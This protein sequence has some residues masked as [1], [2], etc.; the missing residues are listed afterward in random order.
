[1]LR[2]AAL[3][4]RLLLS[5]ARTDK[6]AALE[7][8]FRA[9]PDPD[10]GWA[11]AA[12][13]G[14]LDLPR[15]SA[16]TIRRLCHA[17]VDATLFALSYDF[18]GDLAETA[19]LI[20]PRPGDHALPSRPAPPPPPAPRQPALPGLFDA[21]GPRHPASQDPDPALSAVIAALRAPGDPGEALA[22]L[23]DRL[24]PSARIA[25]LKLCTGGLRVGVSAAMA[26]QALARLSPPDAARE[27]ADIEAMRHALR[28]PYAPLFAWVEGGPAPAV[29]DRLAFRPMMLANPLEEGDLPAMTPADWA[30]EVKWDGVRIE[31][32]ISPQGVRLWSRTGEEM[33]AAFPDLAA[34]LSRPGVVDGELLIL[35]GD[36]PA[37]FNALQERLGRTAPSAALQR[38]SPAAL[39]AYDLLHDGARDLRALPWT[40]RRAALEAWA[41]QAGPRVRLSP[42]VPFADWPALAARREAARGAGEEGLM[43]KR[44]DGAYLPGRPAGQWWKWKRAPLHFD[45]VMVYAQRGHGRRS[46]F[47]SDFTFAAW[48]GE[49]L[50]PVGK[51]YSGISDEELAELDAFVRKNATERFGLVRGVTPSLVLEIACDALVPAPRRRA[52]FSMRFPR[53]ARIRRDKPAAEAETLA[54]MRRIA[55]VEG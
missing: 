37:P 15:V 5:P 47:Y 42:L 7:A 41:A 46:S 8:Y 24:A 10:R 6:L 20:W 21:P 4:E 33:S 40:E 16:G 25:A 45:C 29:D 11:L 28:P 22:G 32:A 39:M 19:A 55:G 44:R 31:A 52:G 50:V 54:A 30:A 48:D 13:C 49:A 1:M 38:K 3:L 26:G 51:A 17:R 14:D 53:I 43:L 27:P 36:V 12:L 34:A 35:S 9:T 2:F 23:L 18:V